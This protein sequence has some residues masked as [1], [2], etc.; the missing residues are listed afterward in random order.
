MVRSVTDQNCIQPYPFLC[1]V[2]P[3]VLETILA[4]RTNG[5]DATRRVG[6][7]NV[8]WLSGLRCFGGL[9]G[10]VLGGWDVVYVDDLS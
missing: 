6:D 7:G 3:F 9:R 2:E 4:N 1:S 8:L 5:V 10:N